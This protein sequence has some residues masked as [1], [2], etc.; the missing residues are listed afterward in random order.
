M[1][2]HPRVQ[3]TVTAPTPVAYLSAKLCDVFPDGTS[4]LVTRGILNLTHRSGHD[5]PEPLEPGLPTAVEIE[6]EATSWTLEQ[7]HRLRLSLAGTDWPNIWPPPDG[8]SLGIERASVELTLPVLD[9][10]PV[11]PGP[12][13]PPPPPKEPDEDDGPPA[14]WRVERDEGEARAVTSY[15]SDYEGAFGARIEERYEGAVGVSPGDPAKAWARGAARY[16]IAWPETTVETEARL[17]LR[18]DVEAYH[19]GVDVVVEEVDGELGRVERRFERT[20]PRRL[21]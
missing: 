20:I 19:V 16:R 2:G 17:D 21:Q 15:G 3:L 9:G 1:L 6:L 5:T 10:P 13:L 7:G 11:V 4:A 8:G 18:S 14:A 12:E